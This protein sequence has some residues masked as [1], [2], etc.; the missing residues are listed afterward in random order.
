LSR[1][2]LYILGAA[3]VVVVVAVVA[4]LW[5]AQPS[6]TA[7]LTT[8]TGT[9]RASMIVLP[10]DR[11]MGSPN[12]PLI[13][14]EFGAPSCPVCARFNQDAMPLL[15]AQYIDTGKVFY[16]FRVFPING[17][18]DGAAEG[19]ARCLP[20]E[21]YFPFIDQLFRNQKDWDPEYGITDVHGALQAQARIAGLP[22]DKADTCM[23]DK[24]NAE[25]INRNAQDAVT[26]YQI[27][28]TPTLVINGAV[29]QAGNIP[30]PT[31]KATLDAFL[32]KK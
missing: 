29:Q 24:A 31:L 11:T 30:W 15:K 20:K 1:N 2:Q 25:R 4:Y 5:F 14:I 27:N 17:S 22:P 23:A 21:A 12:A 16:I 28:G 9:G 18:V 10:D 32:A 19:L 13:V 7:S 8:A 26:R 3:V 6:D